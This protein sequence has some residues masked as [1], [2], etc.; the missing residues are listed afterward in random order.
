M[1]NQVDKFKELKSSSEEFIIPE[2]EELREIYAAKIVKKYMLWSMGSGLIPLPLVD[3]AVLSGVQLKMLG[4]LSRYYGVP[5]SKNTG[6]SIIST[7]VGF[8]TANSL[9]GSI[10]TGVLKSFPAV[11]L[12]GAL[13]MS[14]YSG[15]ITFAIGKIFIQHFESG[16]TFLTF[17]PYKVRKHFEELYQKGQQVAKDLNNN[18]HQM[19]PHKKG[20]KFKF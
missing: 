18:S 15:A 19:H 13:S 16:G 14:I 8:I 9:R 10:I 7:L 20:M 17:K 12:F 4:V 5:F 2:D 1:T 3:T 11:R 6:K